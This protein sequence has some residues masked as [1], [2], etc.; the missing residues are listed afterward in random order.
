MQ[1]ELCCDKTCCCP[2]EG[3]DKVYEKKE[4]LLRV[5]VMG[6]AGAERNREYQQTRLDKSKKFIKQ[7]LISNFNK[8]GNEF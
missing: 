7:I 5:G 4:C 1:R 2:A 8:C 6:V 3:I